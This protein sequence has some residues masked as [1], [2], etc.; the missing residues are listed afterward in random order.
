MADLAQNQI[1]RLVELVAWMS[2]RDIED[3]VPYRDA[4][5]QL[6]ISERTLKVDLQVLLDL[7]ESYKPWLGSLS[8]LLT[9]DG[10]LLGSRGSF[11]RPLRLNRDEVLVLMLGLTG[12]TGG[13]ELA[14]RLGGDF[15]KPQQG[16]E[17]ERAW[18]IGPTPAERLAQLLGLARL[19]RD[20]HRKLEIVYAASAGE[21]SRRIVEP[22]QVVQAR[23]AWYLVAWCEKSKDTRRFRIERILDARLLDQSFTPRPEV[24]RVT[25]F[26]DLLVA[27]DAP[28]ATVA[29]GNQ[30][31]RWMRERYPG[32]KTAS[33]GRYVVEF[34][35]ADP[36][37]LAREV[38]QYGAEA[39]VL[40]PEGMREFVRGMVG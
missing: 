1:Q 3:P 11:R 6:D 32:G 28:T 14:V 35:V 33:D 24:K 30:I 18:A 39:E 17:P 8:V 10:F 13:R 27:A 38:L 25:S 34:S 36:H 4:A 29:F 20:E 22:H 23:G 37:W 12:L 7:T 31:A 5:H 2:Q 21:P 15:V 40:A 19:A 16:T 26:K 9:A